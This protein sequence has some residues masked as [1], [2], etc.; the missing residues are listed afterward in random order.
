MLPFTSLNAATATGVGSSRDLEG[1][2]KNH[3]LIVSTTGTSVSGTIKLE[4]SHDGSLW[5]EL[6]SAGFNEQQ[7]SIIEV[8]TYHV[9]Y[10]RA[11]L[12][13][14]SGSSPVVTASIASGNGD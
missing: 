11:N 9:R 14:L 13:S 8:H 7:P 10:V 12:T 3:T 6:T 5:K 1:S 2:F 4:G